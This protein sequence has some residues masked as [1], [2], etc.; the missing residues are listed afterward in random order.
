[1]LHLAFDCFIESIKIT[2]IVLLMMVIVD[3]INVALEGKL[4]SL[5]S[6]GVWRQYI[7]AALL[8]AMPGC[9]GAFAV[10]SLYVH[11]MVSI[12][13][14][15][16]SMIA[17]SG[18]EAFV[19]LAMM[20]R[21]AMLIFGSLFVCGIISG[22]VSDHI[23]RWLRIQPC[24]ECE[25]SQV[26]PEERGLKHY[27]REHI[28]EHIIRVHLWRVFLW[29]FFAILFIHIGTTYWYLNA[30]VRAHLRLVFFIAAL[31]GILPESGPHMAFVVMFAN[32]LVPF[33]VLFVNSFVQDGH[34]ML[35][36]LSYSVRDALLIK[37][38]NLFLGIAVGAILYALG[39]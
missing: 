4:R 15:I 2:L 29:T 37:V 28:W 14:V 20:P 1:M 19:M 10:V 24:I 25:L 39:L 32:G 7:G 26:H 33:S 38:F 11:G 3:A 35:P 9:L 27:L 8:G 30:F 22:W 23:V 16:A 17:T 34:G 12:G 13:A 21:T 18:D 31:V 5:V 6:G 36:M